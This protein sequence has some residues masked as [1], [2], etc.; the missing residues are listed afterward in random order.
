MIGY[1]F[2]S[3]LV[4]LLPV[5]IMISMLQLVYG[6]SS[7]KHLVSEYNYFCLQFLLLFLVIALNLDNFVTTSILWGAES[8]TTTQQRRDE[9]DVYNAG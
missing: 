5:S 6:K 2:E 3:T 8:W 1:D 7:I 9:L 4:L